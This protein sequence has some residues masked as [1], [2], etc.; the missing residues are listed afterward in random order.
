MLKFFHFLILQVFGFKG[1]STVAVRKFFSVLLGLASL[2]LGVW[3][4]M[5]GVHNLD[6]LAGGVP[7]VLGIG[8]A[9]IGCTIGLLLFFRKPREK[10][11]RKGF[12]SLS[13]YSGPQEKELPE[14]RRGGLTL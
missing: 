2:S 8:V 11:Q 12:V 3:L 5:R 13:I 14:I 4:Y 6:S 9:L 10:I 1:K 7:K